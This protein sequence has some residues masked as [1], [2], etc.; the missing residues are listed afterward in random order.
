MGA[1]CC[2]PAI[3]STD[4]VIAQYLTLPV[5]Y[6]RAARTFEQIGAPEF[7]ILCW[8]A[9]GKSAVAERV[10]DRSGLY[11]IDNKISAGSIPMWAMIVGA[12]N[13][14]ESIVAYAVHEYIRIRGPLPVWINSALL[15]I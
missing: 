4:D 8:L 15:L 11:L 13:G 5:D 6:P 1:C 14:D 3:R 7:A 10:Y 9:A 12:R 2:R